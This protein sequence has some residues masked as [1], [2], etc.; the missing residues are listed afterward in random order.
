M[1]LYASEPIYKGV[2]VED[3]HTSTPG[4]IRVIKGGPIVVFGVEGDNY[5]AEVRI[6]YTVVF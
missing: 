2:G 3:W 4:F 5:D 6:F 1:L